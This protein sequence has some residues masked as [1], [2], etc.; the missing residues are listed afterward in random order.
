MH[1][2]NVVVLILAGFTSRVCAVNF[3]RP[4]WDLGPLQG[5]HHCLLWEANPSYK[6]RKSDK[7][8]GSRDAF[9]IY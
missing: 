6:D 1:R 9:L 7:G 2:D 4:L 5:S 3:T 8:I